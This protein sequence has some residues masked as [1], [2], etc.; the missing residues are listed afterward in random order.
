MLLKVGELAKRTGLTIRTLH[1]YDELGLL[2]P[3]HRSEAGYRLYGRDDLAR[4]HQIQALKQLG[5][6]LADIGDT[7]ATE[8]VALPGIITQQLAVLDSQMEKIERLRLQ[9]T[10]LKV[11][12]DRGDMPEVADW[13]TTLE[14]MTLYDKYLTPEEQKSLEERRQS[15]GSDLDT[16]WPELVKA[17]RDLLDRGVP[18]TTSDAQRRVAE[19][20]ALV[21]ETTGN[22]PGLVHKLDAMTRHEATVQAQTAID[23]ALLNYVVECMQARQRALYAK[24]LTPEQLERVMLGRAS[25]GKQWPPLVAAMRQLFD[26]GAEPHDPAVRELAVQWKALFDVTHAG[27]DGSLKVRLQAA[28]AQEPEL[29]RGTGLDMPLLSFVGRAMA[30]L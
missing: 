25:T 28:Y 14:I 24:Y 20:T 3:S 16:R 27:D 12:M 15:A 8:G 17:M 4:L 29:L 21:D 1:H 11:K 5:L 18:P 19:W 7:L 10:R 9:L 30:A 26:Q 2:K 6:G 23:P 22:D 13:L